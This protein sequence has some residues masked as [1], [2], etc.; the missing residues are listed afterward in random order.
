MTGS[1]SRRFWGRR[2]SGGS[3]FWGFRRW[4]EMRRAREAERCARRIVEVS[5][6]PVR[7]VGSE[8][9]GGALAA[10]P[11]GAAIV[12]IG[13]LTNVAAAVERDREL[14]RRASLRVVGGNLSS[15]GFLPPL[16][17]HEFNFARDRFGGAAGSLRAVEGSRDLSA[18]R[19]S[20]P[21]MR[22]APARGDRRIRTGGGASRAGFAA[23]GEAGAVARIAAVDFPSGTFRRRSPRREC[24]TSGSKSAPFRSSSAGP[25]EFLR[26]FGRPSASTRM[27]RGSRSIS[28]LRVFRR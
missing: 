16:W 19:R 9:A 13:P 1:R 12:A 10:L 24:S 23:L 7:V 20:P 15:V 8:D 6:E 2:G 4:R 21:P 26:A 25:P 11:D 17:P 18:R 3:R 5:G 27:R 28:L 14:L 22:R